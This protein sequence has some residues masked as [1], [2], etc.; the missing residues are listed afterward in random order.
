M[1]HVTV[2]NCQPRLN[3][4]YMPGS[5][6]T[7]VPACFA[8]DVKLCVD[9][10][11]KQ[12]HRETEENGH[13]DITYIALVFRVDEIGFY[14]CWWMYCWDIIEDLWWNFGHIARRNVSHCGR[15]EIEQ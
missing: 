5:A 8:N 2:Y 15:I 7:V 6:L 10:G 1:V 12:A 14:S 4:L 13:N 9:S 3:L 11:G